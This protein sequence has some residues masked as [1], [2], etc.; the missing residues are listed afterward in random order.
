MSTVSPEKAVAALEELKR[1]RTYH[2]KLF[3]RPYPKQQDFLDTG[4][5]AR[6][7]LLMAGNQVGKSETGAFEVSCHLTG[8]YPE[9]WLGRRWD[10]P[11][12]GW[13]VGETGLAT[14]DV[15]QM[16]LCGNPGVVD[17]FGT[18]YIPRD[19]FADKPT[20]GRGVTDGYDMIQVRHISGGTSMGMFKS[21]EQGRQKLQGATLDWVW[22]DEEPPEDIY[23]ELLAR[24]TATKGM[25]IGTF[26][27]LKGKSKVVTK[28]LSEPSPDRTVVTMTLMDAEHIP[29]EERDRI[30]AG[31]PAYQRDAR[32]RGI[33]MLGSGRVYEHLEESITEPTLETVPG[34]W[35]KLWGIDFGIE[36]NFAAVL[37][38]WDRDQDIW[39]IIAAVRMAGQDPLHHVR[40][41]RNICAGAPVAWPH[42]GTQRDKGSG[43]VLATTYR[44]EGARMLQEHATFPEGGYSREAAVAQISLRMSTG[45]WK[46]AA[47]LGDWF[48]EYRSYHRKDGLIVKLNDDLMSASEKLP[49]MQRFA[50]VVP[51]G[52]APDP[53][54]RGQ[55]DQAKDVD[56][57]LWS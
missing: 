46:V 30:I 15:S 39:H 21:Y 13:I 51:M 56:F 26:T 54:G 25:L 3:F 9:W 36:H 10:R 42:D 45:R 19:A 48:E 12:K 43:I 53:R 32:V 14:R 38:A 22:W 49:M 52:K 44:K 40:A 18:G 57:D 6:E 55:G 20:L 41:M 16:K 5:W 31:Y 11:T 7:R 27:P 50:K 17:D 35:A 37:G 4:A 24:I 8:E 1:L 23:T 47:H 29:V 34:H 28:Y 33:P 2:K